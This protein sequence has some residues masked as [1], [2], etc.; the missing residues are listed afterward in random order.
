MVAW[1]LEPGSCPVSVEAVVRGIV[2]LLVCLSLTGCLPK[3]PAG[4]ESDPS[5]NPGE[6]A[7]RAN[8]DLGRGRYADAV[9]SARSCLKLDA[10]NLDCQRALGMGLYELAKAA[11]PIQEGDLTM[12]LSDLERYRRGREDLKLGVDEA[13][14]RAMRDLRDLIARNAKKSLHPNLALGVAGAGGATFGLAPEAAGPQPL[15]GLGL[16][17][18]VGFVGQK[19][20]LRLNLAVDAR[21]HGTAAWLAA[22][23]AGGVDLGIP[24]GRGA[25]GLLFR[26]EGGATAAAAAWPGFLRVGVGGYLLPSNAIELRFFPEV[27]LH[28]AVEAVSV[29]LRV[30]AML[31]LWPRPRTL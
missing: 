1:R 11:R 14:T 13:V 12:A 10:W 30:E 29:S 26:V 18:S 2:A 28:P 9:Q 17:F 23:P 27:E 22:Q 21:F 20:R 3:S 5:E 7:D 16:R 4:V 31:P 24:L 25:G 6:L 15:A 19:L 8:Q